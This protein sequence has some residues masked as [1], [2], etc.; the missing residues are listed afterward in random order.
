[1]ANGQG[2]LALLRKTVQALSSLNADSIKPSNVDDAAA[3][4]RTLSEVVGELSRDP[5]FAPALNSPLVQLSK[6][7][8]ALLEKLLAFVCMPA[9]LESQVAM[10]VMHSDLCC[11][12][13]GQS[14]CPRRM[15]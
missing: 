15:K 9:A 7:L 11:N 4:V 14:I 10:C 6:F 2:L 13:Y 8:H 1:M 5:E 3:H 12:D